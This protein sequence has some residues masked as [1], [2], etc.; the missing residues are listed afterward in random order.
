VL[1]GLLIIILLTACCCC[2]SSEP[3][4]ASSPPLANGYYDSRDSK[5]GPETVGGYGAS[6]YQTRGGP[7]PDEK[8]TE[9]I[10]GRPS[11]DERTTET[12][13]EPGRAFRGHD[14][15]TELIL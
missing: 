10:G 8:R 14:T 5:R 2:R 15:T 7:A 13:R 4:T 11:L 9:T 1:F 3:K 6:G 12:K